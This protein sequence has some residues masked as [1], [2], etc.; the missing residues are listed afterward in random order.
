MRHRLSGIT[1]YR[2][3]ASEREKDE[4]PTYALIREYGSVYLTI[5]MHI[6]LLL[7]HSHVYFVVFRQVIARIVDGSRF[8]EFKALYGETLVAGTVRHGD[9]SSF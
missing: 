2:L 6:V 3:K 8:D 5:I 7:S 1:T 9:F 4:Y